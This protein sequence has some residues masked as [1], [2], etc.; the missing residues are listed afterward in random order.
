[1]TGK[2]VKAIRRTLAMTQEQFASELGCTARS[3]GNW[4]RGNHSP[5]GM[6]LRQ[7]RRLARRAYSPYRSRRSGIV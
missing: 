5:R 7:L 2:D 6:S 3:V 1:M 4:E